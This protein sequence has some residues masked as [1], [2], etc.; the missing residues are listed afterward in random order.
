MK[1][2]SLFVI[3]A[4][5]GGVA[6]AAQ[7]TKR[8]FTRPEPSAYS[9]AERFWMDEVRPLL[10]FGVQPFVEDLKAKQERGNIYSPM[11]QPMKME[12]DSAATP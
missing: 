1:R 6:V 5:V 8:F 2:S 7:P 4:V 11:G 9:P 3:V 12:D 10:K